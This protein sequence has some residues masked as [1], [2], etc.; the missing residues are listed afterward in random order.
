MNAG[1]RTGKLRL[2]HI[3]A[4][5]DHQREIERAIGHM[6]R[7]MSAR[8]SRSSLPKA[9]HLLVKPGRLF[10][11]SDLEREMDNSRPIFQS[12]NPVRA[13]HRRRH[14]PAAAGGLASGHSPRQTPCSRNPHAWN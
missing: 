4:V 3:L 6:P 10:E 11:V 14:P 12:P 9:E 7:Y 1:A 5:I 13:S 8:V 2:R